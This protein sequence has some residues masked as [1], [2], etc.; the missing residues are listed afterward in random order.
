[1]PVSAPT[2]PKGVLDGVTGFMS[3]DAQASI[4]STPFNFQHLCEFQSSEARMCQ[5]KR[6]CDAGHAIR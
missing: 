6:Y 5:V 3:E 2:K 4:G 1:L